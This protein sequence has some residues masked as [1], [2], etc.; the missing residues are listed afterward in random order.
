MNI[1]LHHFFIL[2]EPG[3]NQADLVSNIGLVE[4]T[5]NNHPGQGTANRRFF[6]S[7][8][9][10]E[11]L[12]VRDSKEA[13]NGPGNKLRITDRIAESKAS[14]FGLIMSTSD[15]NKNVPFTGW[16]YCPEYFD[17][18][19]CFHVGE[20]SDLLVEPL[21]IC[22]PHNINYQNNH[23][24]KENSTWVVTELSI[25]VPVVHPTETLEIIASCDEVTLRLN[26]PHHMDLVFNE[27]KQKQSK[28]MR[29][30]LPLV[31]H[32]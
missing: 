25:S 3:A 4:G 19:Q 31:V 1:K 30:E 21:C 12:Y 22:M 28:D 14:P 23:L 11:F 7:N 18:D 15:V 6:L 27:R 20:N 29:P 17:E 5:K 32:W 13:K 9:T 2:T 8:S 10:L 26:E 24:Q 16:R